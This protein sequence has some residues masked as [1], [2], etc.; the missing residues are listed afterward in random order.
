MKPVRLQRRRL[1]RSESGATGVEYGI[2]AGLVALL[3]VGGAQASGYGLDRMFQVIGFFMENAAD[4]AQ[5]AGG[6]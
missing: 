6:N 1:A 4:A 3:I 2:I 5:S